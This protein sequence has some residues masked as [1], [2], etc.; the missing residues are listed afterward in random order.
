M[1]SQQKEQRK[2]ELYEVPPNT[3][4]EFMVQFFAC[5]ERKGLLNTAHT[6][7]VLDHSGRHMDADDT[8]D[9]QVVDDR[10]LKKT[11]SKSPDLHGLLL[12]EIRS[13]PKLRP[14]RDGKLLVGTPRFQINMDNDQEPLS[15]AKQ[16]IKPDFSLLFQNSLEE[17]SG[18]E[19]S[20]RSDSLTSSPVLD[21][22]FASSTVAPPSPPWHGAGAFLFEDKA[23]STSRL[24]RRHTITV[25]GAGGGGKKH[26]RN[27]IEYL[28][29][30]LEELTHIRSV[31]TKAELESLAWQPELYQQVSKRKLCFTCRRSKF[32]LF[33]EWGT[34]CKICQRTVCSKCIRKMNVPTDHFR[35]IPVYSLSSSLLTNEM[36]D[37]VKKTTRTAPAPSV[38]QTRAS[39][40]T[41]NQQQT[42]Q[43][44]K[45]HKLRR[46]DSAEFLFEDNSKDT[47]TQLKNVHN[48]QSV[49]QS[50]SR[51]VTWLKQS[52][53]GPL[54]AICSECSQM[55]N[56]IVR[57]SRT[58]SSQNSSRQTPSS[59]RWR[60]GTITEHLAGN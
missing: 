39:S 45:Q 25:C 15:P 43:L 50:E 16:V 2:R 49:K 54:M 14:T 6:R 19:E 30:T 37:I 35:N 5:L 3:P 8:C 34:K 53:K 57:S 4:T 27:C 11:R 38:P 20:L 58:M 26:V 32:T 42:H 10:K 46:P 56:E 24:Q 60:R 1:K 7:D 23:Q 59:D 21:T 29:L 31:F 28:S 48:I 9:N 12:R 40:P 18:E 22:S 52:L 33:G 44:H 41:R 13:K 17:S 36:R 47:F 55:V 51:K